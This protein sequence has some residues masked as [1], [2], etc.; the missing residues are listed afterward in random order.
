MQDQIQIRIH[1]Y[2]YLNEWQANGFRRRLVS[3]NHASTSL[4]LL[5][6]PCNT[7]HPEL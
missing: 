3:S 2:G 7:Q 5:P 1:D 6:S 4:L